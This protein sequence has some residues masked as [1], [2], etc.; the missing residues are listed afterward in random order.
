V[1]GRVDFF[2]EHYRIVH[3]TMIAGSYF[4]DFEVLNNIKRNFTTRAKVDTKI[5]TLRKE[6]YTDIIA[7]DYPEVKESM[8]QEAKIKNISTYRCRQVVMSI[9]NRYIGATGS[10]KPTFE[11]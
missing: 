3:K 9:T 10:S 7:K 8:I 2:L 4:G 5:L 6:V 11:D 1:D